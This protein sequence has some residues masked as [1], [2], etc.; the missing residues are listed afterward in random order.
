MVA[1][2]C[3]KKDFENF[4]LQTIVGHPVRVDEDGALENSTDVT[5]LFV[6]EFKISM[7]TTGGYESCLN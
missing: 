7:E 5:K 6:E 1:I 3:H 4:A 2:V